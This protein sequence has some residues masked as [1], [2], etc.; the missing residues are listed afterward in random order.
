MFKTI[1]RSVLLIL[2]ATIF[3]CGVMVGSG[4]W[5]LLKGAGATWNEA[6]SDMLDIQ[7]VKEY[8]VGL[9]PEDWEDRLWE[10]IRVIAEKFSQ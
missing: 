7:K 4:K 3:T 10:Q 5:G 8:A 9:L 6:V 2:A 1:K